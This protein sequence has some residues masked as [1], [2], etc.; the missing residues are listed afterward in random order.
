M[1]KVIKYGKYIATLFVIAIIAAAI[2]IWQHYISPEAV[3]EIAEADSLVAHS[4]DVLSYNRYQA[5]CDD[6]AAAKV[7]YEYCG[8]KQG[9]VQCDLLLAVVYFGIGQLETCQ[10]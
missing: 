7:I 3:L 4:Q 1:N 2:A 6:L 5:A 10:N 8:N 9:A